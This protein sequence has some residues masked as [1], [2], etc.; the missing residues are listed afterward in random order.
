VFEDVRFL[1]GLEHGLV[2]VGELVEFEV[3]VVA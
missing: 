2:E 3:W 1:G